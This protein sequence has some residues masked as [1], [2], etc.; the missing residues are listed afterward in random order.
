MSTP[1]TPTIL[2]K[3]AWESGR[4]TVLNAAQTLLGVNIQK[5]QKLHWNMSIFPLNLSLQD[6]KQNKIGINLKEFIWGFVTRL[7]TSGGTPKDSTHHNKGVESIHLRQE[8]SLGDKQK[9]RRR[10]GR[11]DFYRTQKR[12]QIKKGGILQTREEVWV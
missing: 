12:T 7:V 1:A 10:L 4:Q 9:E 11:L 8:I 2:L 3:R 5:I 6:R